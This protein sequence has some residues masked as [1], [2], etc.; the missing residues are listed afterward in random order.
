[1]VGIVIDG[2]RDSRVGLR[3]GLDVRRDGGFEEIEIEESA[4]RGGVPAGQRDGDR[5]LPAATL[6]RTWRRVCTARIAV[7]V[8]IEAGGRVAVERN[9]NHAAVR[10]QRGADIEIVDLRVVI[11]H[12]DG[13]TGSAGDPAK[14]AIEE[15]R[16]DGP[17]GACMLRGRI[18]IAH[19]SAAR[20]GDLEWSLALRVGDGPVG[21]SRRPLGAGVSRRIGERG[22]EGQP[23]LAKLI[24]AQCGEI[25]R[26]PARWRRSCRSQA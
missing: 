22:R 21:E 6:V 16:L 17:G 4:R 5:G 10:V 2:G 23:R 11:L 25:E 24:D 1:M 8:A 15:A 13:V 14:A 12:R 7:Q 9:R 3:A 18:R 26:S 20:T 19:A